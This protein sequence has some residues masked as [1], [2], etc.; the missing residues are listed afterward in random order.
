MDWVLAIL[1]FLHIGGAILAFGPAYAFL[2][3]GPMAAG[4]PMHG[5]FAL[6]FQQRVA[7][8]LMVPL[9]VF[10]GITGVLL[11]WRISFE[12]FTRGWL[13][14]SIVL[15]LL[16]LGIAFGIMLPALRTLVP[17]TAGGPPPAMAEGTPPPGPPPHIVATIR[18]A[19]LGGML[20]ATLV[21]IIV[22]LMVTKPF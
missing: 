7:T 9:A 15:Y 6:R 10:Q 17:A 1:L 16:A 11:V 4:E 8:K 20:N 21:L 12:L 13:V 5:N 14:V 3:L 2:F 22:F 19:R 18:R